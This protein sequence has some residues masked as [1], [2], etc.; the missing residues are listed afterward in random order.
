[1]STLFGFAVTGEL[2]GVRTGL[3]AGRVQTAWGDPGAQSAGARPLVRQ[4]GPVEVAF[5]ADRVVMIAVYLRRGL[6]ELP[7][8][9]DADLSQRT[10]WPELRDRLADAG[11]T[12][13]AEP[14]LTFDQQ[15]AVRIEPS[16]VLA[17]FG[18]QGLDSLQVTAP[19][20]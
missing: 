11:C 1:V 14:T 13:R 15:R 8:Q 3:S 16:R 5:R 9:V 20:G 7:G 6:A 19:E 18:G 4:Y 17:V 12:W 2:G 10:A